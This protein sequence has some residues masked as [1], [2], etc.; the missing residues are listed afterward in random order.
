MET[1]WKWCFVNDP[2]TT[3]DAGGGRGGGTTSHL[4]GNAYVHHAHLESKNCL[5]HAF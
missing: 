5:H 1:F 3:A 2:L 4:A